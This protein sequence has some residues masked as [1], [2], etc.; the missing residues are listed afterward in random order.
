MLCFISL[1][2]WFTA[3]QNLNLR[4]MVQTCN[5]VPLL[6]LS[7]I[8]FPMLTVLIVILLADVLAFV[9][10]LCVSHTEHWSFSSALRAGA[11]ECVCP[12]C[13]RLIQM[14]RG[15]FGRSHIGKKAKWIPHSGFEG[16]TNNVLSII[17]SHPKYL[18]QMCT[19]LPDFLLTDQHIL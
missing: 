2:V 1:L 18:Y 9:R 16:Q 10:Q 12:I 3:Q 19:V 8:Y 5:L 15:E 17:F 4:S 11:K 6:S 13:L 14:P 7:T